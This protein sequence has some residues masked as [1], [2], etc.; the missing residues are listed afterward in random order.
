MSAVT[1]LTSAV[2][3]QAK[4]PVSNPCD[5]QYQHLQPRKTVCPTHK[6]DPHPQPCPSQTPTPTSSVDYPPPR[7]VPW[8]CIT[9]MMRDD[10]SCLVC[11]FNKLDY[12]PRLNFHQEMGFPALAKHDYICRKDVTV[13]ETIV[14]QFNKKLLS[15]TNQPRPN[16]TGSRRASEEMASVTVSARRV[17]SPSIPITELPP[18][19]PFK[20]SVPPA[21]HE[22]NLLLLPNQVVPVT[23]SNGY[24][25]L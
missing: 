19:L 15:I 22:I 20:Y 16:R 21:P 14:D 25:D 4:R 13:S 8:N 23:N 7:G 3:F 17:H 11:H 1:F 10:K 9:A 2:S 18:S 12:T 5:S 24:A 6:R